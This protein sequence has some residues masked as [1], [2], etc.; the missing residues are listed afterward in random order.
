MTFRPS[1][2]HRHRLVPDDFG[3][4]TPTLPHP[5]DDAS[6]AV[7]VPRVGRLP[8]AS[9][10]F[11]LAVD[12]LAVRLGVPVITASKGLSPASHFPV[13]F[14]LPVASARQ[15]ATR[16]AWRTSGSR[17]TLLQPRPLRTAREVFTSSRS[18]LSNARTRT[19]LAA[20]TIRAWGR[21]PLRCTFCRPVNGRPVHRREGNRTSSRCC[22]HLPCLLSRFA[23]LSRDERPEGSQPAFAWGNVA[24]GSTP[25]RSITDLPSLAPSSFTR[26]PHSGPCGPPAPGG[27]G[28]GLTVFHADNKKGLGTASSPVAQ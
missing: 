8:S 13:G 7:R 28:Y 17:A 14:R 15:G 2:P 3:L 24:L 6:H 4:R 21:R 20:F 27:Q 23:K 10:G 18:S 16:H 1:P 22:R 5:R 25:I 19:R 11:H 9:F 12:T 26:S